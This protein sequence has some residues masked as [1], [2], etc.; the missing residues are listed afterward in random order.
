VSTNRIAV[1]RRFES[2]KQKQAPMDTDGAVLVS[3]GGTAAESSTQAWPFAGILQSFGGTFLLTLVLA[4]FC[5]LA[6]VT[7]V[8]PRREFL[9]RA[10]PPVMPNTRARKLELLQKYKEAG[11]VDLVVLGSSRSMLLSPDLLESL[12][13]QRAF[14]AGVFSAAPND[15]LSI[16]RVMKQQGIVPKTLVIGLDA[17]SLDPGNIPTLDFNSNLALTSALEGTAPNLP[18]KLRHWARLYKDSLSPYY[19][20]NIAESIWIW[21]KP[22]P[23]LF[24]LQPNGQEEDRTVDLQIQSGVY[25]RAEK[26]K[27]C[28]DSEQAKFANFHDASPELEGYLKQLFSEAARDKVRLVLWITPVNPEA[29]GIIQ[30][31]P[32]AGPNFR[33]AEDHLIQLGAMSHLPVRD[34]TDSQSFGGRP[35]SWYDCVHYSQE[36]ADRIAKKLFTYGL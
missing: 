11:P 7:V 31:D 15:Y 5:Y 35:D 13:G 16:Y 8:N 33:T 29:L 23:P 18:A 19:A 12:A 34:L 26:F 20:Q 4:V 27:H 17:E 3:A 36:D 28:E 21:F 32:Q 22:R 25:P 1:E 6:M 9:G 24:E 14:N 30:K 2:G 10:F